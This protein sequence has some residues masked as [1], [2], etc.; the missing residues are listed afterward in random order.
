MKYDEIRQRQAKEVAKIVFQMLKGRGKWVKRNLRRS[1]LKRRMDKVD[2]IV[3]PED[4]ADWNAWGTAFASALAM[5]LV[6]AVNEIYDLEGFYMASHN[7]TRRVSTTL[8]PAET[9][10]RYQVRNQRNL[11]SISDRIRRDVNNTIQNW[12]D[13][14]HDFTTLMSLMD[15]IFS[16]NAADL[17]SNTEVGNATTQA[18]LDM[19]GQYGLTLF[20][21]DATLDMATCSYCKDMNGQVLGVYDPF[22][23]DDSH[24]GC[25]CIATPVMDAAGT[26]F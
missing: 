21:W 7:M 24:P 1:N 25:R 6:P 13:G 18:S 14:G 20:R 4:D 22:P 11:T 8:N 23:P 10:T 16:Q 3:F 2:G 9:V 15:D 26:E 5:A 19:I 12:R 17:I